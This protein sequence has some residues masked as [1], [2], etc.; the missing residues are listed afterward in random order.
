MLELTRYEKYKK[1]RQQILTIDPLMCEILDGTQLINDFYKRINAINPTILKK[2]DN[3]DILS[4]VMVLSNHD[5]PDIIFNKFSNFI[6]FINDD[7]VLEKLNTT[8]NY[9]NNYSKKTIIQ[10]N[11]ISKA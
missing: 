8:T 10:D 7:E 9:I 2:F 11:E 6:N 3:D 1:Y 4:S 5:K